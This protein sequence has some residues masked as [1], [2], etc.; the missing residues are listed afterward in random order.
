[1]K[2]GMTDSGLFCFSVTG[3]GWLR[4]KKR[5]SLTILA[6]VSLAASLKV[7]LSEPLKPALGWELPSQP[8]GCVSAQAYNGSAVLTQSD[9]PL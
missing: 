8:H 3:L 1:M 7:A 5:R 2:E 6:E 9:P 4:S